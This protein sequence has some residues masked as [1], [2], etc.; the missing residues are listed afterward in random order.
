MA[1][2]MIMRRRRGGRTIGQLLRT[3]GCTPP[4]TTIFDRPSGQDLVERS[5]VGGRSVGKKNAGH[6]LGIVSA[7]RLESFQSN[8]S[9]RAKS[10]SSSFVCVVRFR[11][12][13]AVF[14]H[15][16]ASQVLAASGD[17]KRIGKKKVGGT[18]HFLGLPW[19]FRSDEE[20]GTGAD[21][22][23]HAEV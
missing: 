13:R 19:R 10:L 2:G 20:G 14:S 12:R 5:V 3:A 4:R 21:D 18:A 6:D 7:E 22:S 8:A 16:R 17:R 11:R 9:T 15:A 1:R 23:I